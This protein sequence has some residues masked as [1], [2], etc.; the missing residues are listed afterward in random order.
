MIIIYS[1][2][3]IKGV[4]GAYCDPAYF[5]GV[6]SRATLVISSDKK[7][8]EAYKAAGVDVKGFPRTSAPKAEV[9]T[10]TE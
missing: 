10:E 7:I 5:D 8:Q 3:A 9:E 6:D 2:K 4:G 1:K